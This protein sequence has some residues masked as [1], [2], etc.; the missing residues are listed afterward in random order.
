MNSE[1]QGNSSHDGDE[2][3]EMMKLDNGEFDVNKFLN[4]IYEK[5]R[6]IESRLV[7][8]E[9][10]FEDYVGDY[11]ES[12]LGVLENELDN[13][14]DLEQVTTR[15]RTLEE[16]LKLEKL[17]THKIGNIE[18]LEKILDRMKKNITS[19]GDRLKKVEKREPYVSHHVEERKAEPNKAKP[20]VI[21]NRV[22]MENVTKGKL[23]IILGNISQTV[24]TILGVCGGFCALDSYASHKEDNHGL[25]VLGGG[26][27][28]FVIGLAIKGVGNVKQWYYNR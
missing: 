24:G 17:R 10:R 23:E 15:L 2:S 1:I 18:D 5:V 4:H 11:I 22:F 28:I 7:H 13:K 12:R 21:E 6:Y 9:T 19:M 26:A 3:L 27:L 25:Y 16:N 14:T 20:D 8:I